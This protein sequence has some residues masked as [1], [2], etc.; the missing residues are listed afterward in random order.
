MYTLYTWTPDIHTLTPNINPCNTSNIWNGQKIEEHIEHFKPF[1]NN[2]M[3]DETKLTLTNSRRCFTKQKIHHPDKLHGNMATIK[4]IIKTQKL[5]WVL[6]FFNQEMKKS[7]YTDKLHQTVHLTWRR[8]I[9]ITTKPWI[10]ADVQEVYYK[11]SSFKKVTSLWTHYDG[12]IEIQSLYS[13]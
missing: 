5:I 1:Y 2:E 10:W 9:W 4:Y 11:V 3:N 12:E 6:T 7:R 13:C 8:H